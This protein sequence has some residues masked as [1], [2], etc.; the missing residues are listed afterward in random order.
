MSSV[1]AMSNMPT[2]ELPDMTETHSQSPCGWARTAHTKA[3]APVLPRNYTDERQCYAEDLPCRPHYYSAQ[4]AAQS[5]SPYCQQPQK[6]GFGMSSSQSSWQEY[7]PERWEYPAPP[8]QHAAHS[9]GQEPVFQD[10]GA[11]SADCWWQA[12]PQGGSEAAH[13]APSNRGFLESGVVLGRFS[14]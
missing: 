5:T 14:C 6:H 11:S 8:R 1:P 10:F 2:I 3:H 13:A 9:I 7:R 4:E 12:P